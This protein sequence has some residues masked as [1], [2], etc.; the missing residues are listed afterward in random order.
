M[1]GSSRWTVSV[2]FRLVS[3]IVAWFGAGSHSVV[4][5]VYEVTCG[6]EGPSVFQRSKCAVG[7][8]VLCCGVFSLFCSFQDGV[9]CTGAVVRGQWLETRQL[10]DDVPSMILRAALGHH[11]RCFDE[12]FSYDF[13]ESE[14]TI[15]KSH[16]DV[17][18]R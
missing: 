15:K 11:S 17:G 13:W 16:P 10:N 6:R 14:N 4:G 3:R 8:G 18:S 12:R 5:V 2:G 7:C 9:E 1:W